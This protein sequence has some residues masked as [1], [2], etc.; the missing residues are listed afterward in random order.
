MIECEDYKSLIK[1][2]DSENTLFYLDPPYFNITKRKDYYRGN[3]VWQYEEF[4]ELAE[5]LKNI[6]GKF[7]LSLGN[8]PEVE[9]IFDGFYIS[10]KKRKT[11]I[12]SVK[13]YNNDIIEMIITNIP[14][15]ERI[16]E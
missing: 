15:E 12:N 9:K 1:R 3:G 5:V 14:P 13:E 11:T 16:G 6:K 2:Y 10:T 7:V 4:K 8:F